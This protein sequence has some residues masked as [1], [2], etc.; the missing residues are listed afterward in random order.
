MQRRKFIQG[1]L[2]TLPLV[3]LAP[4]VRAAETNDSP[5]RRGGFKVEAGK[6][7][8]NE[9][10]LFEHPN[11]FKCKV[12]GEDSNEALY[13][14][15][16]DDIRGLGSPLHIHHHQDEWFFITEGN[17]LVKVGE[18]T[19]HLTKGDSVFGPKMVPHAFL[20]IGDGPHRMTL[21]YQPAGMMERFFHDIQDPAY[22]KGKDTKQVFSEHDME[23]VGPKLVE[24]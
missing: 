21:V 15:E 12:S 17:Y 24:G 11:R 22:K 18:D 7:R 4:F 23:V 19:F 10:T 20:P 1:A 6:D 8:F 5:V 14:M 2:S 9:E 13:I 16:E 3:S